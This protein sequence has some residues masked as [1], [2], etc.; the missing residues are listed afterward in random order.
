MT[1]TQ[2]I[3]SK[4]IKGLYWGAT[5]LLSLMVLFSAFGYFT[6]EQM[7]AAFQHLGFPGYFRVELGIAKIL[8]VIAI[9]IPGK[10]ILKEWA[11][12]GFTITFVSAFIAHVSSGDPAS[13]VIAPII[14]LILLTISYATF[15]R[16]R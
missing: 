12:A 15:K 10:T 7:V 13:V 4:M 1:S 3:S 16:V 6:S 5:G 2:Q 8:G 9:L 11:Y 14:A